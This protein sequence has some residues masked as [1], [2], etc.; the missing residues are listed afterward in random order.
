MERNRKRPEK[1]LLNIGVTPDAVKVLL[2]ELKN[3]KQKTET[4]NYVPGKQCLYNVK[5]N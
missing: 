5:Q 1:V 4:N 2:R 3:S